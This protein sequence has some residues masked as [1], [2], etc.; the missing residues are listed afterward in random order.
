VSFFDLTQSAMGCGSAQKADVFA[1][2]RTQN[3]LNTKGK[4]YALNG[5][6][7]IVVKAGRKALPGIIFC[8][9]QISLEHR[10]V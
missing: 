1:H 5:V 9:M 4:Q 6:N 10:T 3:L 8:L 2:Y 7:E